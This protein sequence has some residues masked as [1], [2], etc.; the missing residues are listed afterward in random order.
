MLC[1]ASWVVDVCAI[2]QSVFGCNPPLT[3]NK[4][5][6]LATGA[7]LTLT[8]QAQNLTPTVSGLHANG[9]QS[10][11]KLS[12]ELTCYAALVLASG[13]CLRVCL[14]LTGNAV[15]GQGASQRRG[16]SAAHL[17]TATAQDPE[18]ESL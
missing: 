1:G 10:A 9:I 15:P 16:Q 18:R 17:I 4:V 13:L 5:A 2:L 14:R 11:V 3:V 12:N 8:A 7:I 6:L